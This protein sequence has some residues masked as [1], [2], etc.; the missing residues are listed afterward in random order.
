VSG[1]NGEGAADTVNDKMYSVAYA[2][3]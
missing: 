3:P 2:K 1:N